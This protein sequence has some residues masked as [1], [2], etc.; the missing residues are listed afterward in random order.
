MCDVT[1]KHKL[2]P[3]GA[4]LN[5]IGMFLEIMRLDDVMMSVDQSECANRIINQSSCT[6]VRKREASKLKHQVLD[7]TGI[8]L[9]DSQIFLTD[10]S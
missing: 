2:A 6:C 10:F 7:F 9:N 1:S 5:F 8:L 3:K 4:F